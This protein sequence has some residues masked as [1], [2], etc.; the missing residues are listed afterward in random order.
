[1][2]DTTDRVG[3]LIANAAACMTCGEEHQ[4][5]P[6]VGRRGVSWAS[7]ID[8]HAYRRRLIDVEWLRAWAA[9]NP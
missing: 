4:P 3:R 9:A 1:V 2:T 5:G 6:A 7:P 8:G